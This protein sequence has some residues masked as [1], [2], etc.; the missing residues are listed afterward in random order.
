M[1]YVMFGIFCVLV[2]YCVPYTPHD[3]SAKGPADGPVVWDTYVVC[4][5]DRSSSKF[6]SCCGA[7]YI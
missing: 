5:H 2:G 1:H 6:E 3:L 4:H 7:T